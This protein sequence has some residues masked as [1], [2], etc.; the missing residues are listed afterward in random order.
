M[1]IDT[2]LMRKTAGFITN[3][4][5]VSKQIQNPLLTVLSFNKQLFTIAANPPILAQGLCIYICERADV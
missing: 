5:Y 1:F 2:F 3:K 4:Q